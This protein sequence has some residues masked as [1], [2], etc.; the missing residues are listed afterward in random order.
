MIFVLFV[1]YVCFEFFELEYNKSSDI[2]FVF[3]LSLLWSVVIGF[4][5]NFIFNLF[6]KSASLDIGFL[7]NKLIFF[8]LF[9]LFKFV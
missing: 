5:F 9:E 6:K 1:E 8:F 2:R 7:Y 4:V 3:E